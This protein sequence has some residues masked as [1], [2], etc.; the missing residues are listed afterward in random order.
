VSLR[1]VADGEQT[2][3]AL[4]TDETG[5][6]D[7]IALAVGSY[8]VDPADTPWWRCGVFEVREGA[9]SHADLNLVGGAVRVTVT[10]QDGVALDDVGILGAKGHET[11]RPDYRRDGNT[12]KIGGMFWQ[13]PGLGP[14]TP[15]TQC[16]EP[17]PWT[18][19]AYRHGYNPG[20]VMTSVEPGEVRRVEIRLERNPEAKWDAWSAE[21]RT[22]F[23]AVIGSPGSK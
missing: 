13:C 23:D 20:R 14:L 1:P 4:A 10:D 3:I 15:R 21:P 17:G 22:R 6:S 11:V 7:R 2:Y 16:L 5:R 8:E 9:V 12:I 18:I 19:E